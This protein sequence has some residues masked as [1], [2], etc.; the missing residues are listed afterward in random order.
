[1]KRSGFVRKP[2]KEYATLGRSKPIAR[3][4]SKLKTVRRA[5]TVAEGSKYLTACRGEPCYLRVP[6]ICCGRR[7]TVVPCHSN[8]S[9]HGKGG[10]LKAKHEFSVPGCFTC[11]SWLDQGP[12]ARETKV[13]T[14]DTALDAWVPVR[15][16][17]MGLPLTE[18]A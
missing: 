17:K 3:G 5:P 2:G 6:G 9:K 11:H 18:A 14:F 4:T 10:A 7:D 15:A 1:M 8:Q 16:A 13:L 12:A